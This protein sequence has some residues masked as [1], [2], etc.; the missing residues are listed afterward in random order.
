MG[1]GHEEAHSLI[2]MEFGCNRILHCIFWSFELH[3]LTNKIQVR[4]GMESTEVLEKVLV[5]ALW[6][7][8]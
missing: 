4:A 5:E 8:H 7:K 6:E 2:C 3:F 1:I